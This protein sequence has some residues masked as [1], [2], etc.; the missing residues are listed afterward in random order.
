MEKLRIQYQ[1][2]KDFDEKRFRED[3]GQIPL[4]ADYIF[5]DVDDTGWALEWPLTDVINK[6]APIE[7]RVTKSRKPQYP[8]GG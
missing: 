1:S 3:V 6:H 5:D 4:D 8:R 7:E 2:F